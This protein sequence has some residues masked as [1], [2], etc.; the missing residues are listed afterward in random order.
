MIF[1]AQVMA[2]PM[3]QLL[4]TVPLALPTPV[5]PANTPIFPTNV[6][7]PNLVL[8]PNLAAST[9]ISVNTTPDDTKTMESQCDTL[10]IQT[11]RLDC[12]NETAESFQECVISSADT[13]DSEPQFADTYTLECQTQA[14]YSNLVGNSECV[15]KGRQQ[16]K[17][18]SLDEKKF[19]EKKV[20]QK[21]KTDDSVKK[22]SRFQV[23]VVK[24]D[25]AV[26]GMFHC[27]YQLFACTV[28]SN[29]GIPFSFI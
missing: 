1:Y 16:D 8:Q 22:I 17:R 2:Q 20:Q 5:Q 14:S 6:L 15:F 27:L 25:T 10:E 9:D 21:Q 13:V 11:R 24:E 28:H 7:H 18:E 23:S 26:A 12:N 29:R 4:T 19:Q 3:A